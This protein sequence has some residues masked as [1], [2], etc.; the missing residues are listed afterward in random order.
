MKLLKLID[1]NL[2]GTKGLVGGFT[3]PHPTF[4]IQDK[5]QVIM[6]VVVALSAQLSSSGGSQRHC[7][8][9]PAAQ[10]AT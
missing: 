4:T 10:G 2:P 7:L 5:V 8:Q 3:F 6:T 9:F 1:N